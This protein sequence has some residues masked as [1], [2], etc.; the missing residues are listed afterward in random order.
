MTA[1]HAR[2]T[3]PRL[4]R[5]LVPGLIAVGVFLAAT[6]G[7]SGSVPLTGQAAQPMPHRL[8]VP[9]LARD[10]AIPSRPGDFTTSATTAP[11][12]S[13]VT[14]SVSVTA[15]NT[16]RMIVDIEVY[17]PN[18]ARVFQQPF[19]DQVFRPGQTRSYQA[20]F[21][22]AAGAPPGT[23]VVKAGLFSTDWVDLYHWNNE[24]ATFLLP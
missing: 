8:V 13:G 6:G 10:G 18:G 7:L 9:A 21:T 5:P 3:I 19:Y 24:A 22:P 15:K 20:V 1:T 11:A 4:F 23:Y 14:L 16:E 17:A 12:G 2:R